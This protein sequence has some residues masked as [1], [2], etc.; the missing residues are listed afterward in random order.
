MKSEEKCVESGE[1]AEREKIC[2][3]LE[4]G[5]AVT[6]EE[7]QAFFLHQLISAFKQLL[8]YTHLCKRRRNSEEQRG[9]DEEQS[10]KK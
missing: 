7:G 9:A 8:L 6:A 1:T 5:R 10:R 4:G 2:N 3:Y